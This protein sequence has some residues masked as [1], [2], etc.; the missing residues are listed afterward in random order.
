MEDVFSVHTH[1]KPNRMDSQILIQRL[2]PK[3]QH[4][5]LDYGIEVILL[6]YRMVNPKTLRRV[7]IL[8]IQYMYCTVAKCSAYLK[9]TMD[10]PGRCFTIIH[11]FNSCIS[12]SR[13]VS[14]TEHLRH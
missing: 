8:T 12:S 4:R 1:L 2:Q 9:I 13:Q 5:R 7:K 11:R 14:T 10:V 6:V 3:C